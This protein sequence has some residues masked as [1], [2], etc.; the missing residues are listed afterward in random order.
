MYLAVQSI[1]PG[2]KASKF[3]EEFELSLYYEWKLLN[4]G[5]I[6]DKYIEGKKDPIILL[7]DLDG[8]DDLDLLNGSR[9]RW[10]IPA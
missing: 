1:D 9:G 6:V 7:A 8:D 10:S 5:G 3:S 2:I 4:Q